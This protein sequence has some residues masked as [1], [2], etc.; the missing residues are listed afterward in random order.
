M[1]EGQA[2]GALGASDLSE[3]LDLLPADVARNPNPANDAAAIERLA[4]DLELGR[5]EDGAEFL[6]LE[7]VAQVRLV[8]AVA[9]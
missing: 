4:E 1:P 5:G 9:P 7:A 2:F 3:R 8:H 6:D